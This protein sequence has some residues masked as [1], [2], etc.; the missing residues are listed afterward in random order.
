L[1]VGEAGPLRKPATNGAPL[2]GSGAGLAAAIVR[3]HM[4]VL[5]E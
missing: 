5:D 3:S 2:A 4:E 1:P